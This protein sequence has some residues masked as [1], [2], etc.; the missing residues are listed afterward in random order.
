MSEALKKAVAIAGGQSSLAKAVG[1]KQQ[2]I[3]NWLNRDGRPAAE[4]VL[5]IEAAVGG[6]VTR[7]E[8]RPD[9]FGPDVNRE[10]A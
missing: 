3:W 5:A 8:L 6:R 7:H 4:Y 1:V 2:H 9:V 10:A